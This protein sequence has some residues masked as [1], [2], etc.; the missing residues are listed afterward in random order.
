MDFHSIWIKVAE[1][2]V[3]EC[4]SLYHLPSTMQAN[5]KKEMV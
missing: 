1:E 5:I 2:L 4:I 3:A